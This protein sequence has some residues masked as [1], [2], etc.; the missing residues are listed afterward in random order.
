MIRIDTE[1][2]RRLLVARHQ[3]DP[4]GRSSRHLTDAVAALALV[5][6]TD[7]TT[8]YLSIQARSGVSA[9]DIDH[10]FY[11]E[12]SLLRHTTIRR[13]VFTMPLDVAPIAHGA[14]NGPL[15]S[16]LR[17]N[18][19]AWI[20][21]SPDTDDDAERFM[22]AVERDVVDWLTERG[23]ATGAALADHVPGLR[24]RIDPAPGKPHSRPIRI[25][26]KVLELL[27]AEGRIARGRPAGNDFTSGAWTWEPMGNWVEPA[28]FERL[29]P[30][31][32][33]RSLIERYLGVCG[34]AT[35]TDMAWWTGIAKG[36]IKA[37]LTAL[38]AIEVD[39]EGATE[40][41]YVLSGDDLDAPSMDAT[42]ALLPGLDSTTM[43]WKQR[44]WYVDDSAALGL[45]DRN[46]NAGPTIWLD[47]EVV[48]SW[49]QRADGTIATRFTGS[50]TVDVE[51][52]VDELAA[53]LGDVRIKWRFPT[54]ITK[55]LAAGPSPI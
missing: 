54:P 15:V 40:P 8:P 25:T 53:W 7:P 18:V 39:L 13:T 28:V 24:V 16:K 29:D 11:T 1:Q 38:G 55:E 33:L 14:F 36:P 17:S 44:S 42:V 45:F 3:L 48:G 21:T 6:S 5:H 46:G 34:P 22:R 30:V 4:S 12:R 27:A 37:S 26:S 10:A 32:S 20:R 23:P 47:G 51:A 41:G 43:G 2:R 49:T 50:T 19:I 9:V 52:Q 35:L 31:E